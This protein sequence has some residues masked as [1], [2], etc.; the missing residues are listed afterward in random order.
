M[1]KIK[2]KDVVVQKLEWK[3]TNRQ[4]NGWIWLNLICSS[5]MQLVITITSILTPFNMG[6]WLIHFSICYGKTK[7]T[8]GN[9]YIGLLTEVLKHMLDRTSHCQHRWRT[10]QIHEFAYKMQTALSKL[11]T[12]FTA[13]FTAADSCDYTQSQ[14]QSESISRSKLL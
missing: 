4:K 9:Q 2:V 10:L 5:V 13:R 14:M 12:T 6:S 11:Y 7:R 8:F 1:Q 3:L